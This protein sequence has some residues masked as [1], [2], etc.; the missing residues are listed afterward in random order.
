MHVGL[1]RQPKLA[2]ASVNMPVASP[3][4]HVFIHCNSNPQL[5][6]PISPCRL[7]QPT[8]CF[9]VAATQQTYTCMYIYMYTYIH[10]Y[11]N[12]NNKTHTVTQNTKR[13]DRKKNEY[14]YLYMYICIFI[15]LFVYLLI[16]LFVLM[17]KKI[18]VHD[19]DD[20]NNSNDK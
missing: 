17:Y 19:S 9:E 18:L 16:Y 8:E 12:T 15:Y 13:N 20:D 3:H 4:L 10:A 2:V 7:P 1:R 14:M 11:H 6:T 5:A